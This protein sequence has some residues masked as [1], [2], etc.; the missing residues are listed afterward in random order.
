MPGPGRGNTPRTAN[1]AA[2]AEPENRAKAN[3]RADGTLKRKEPPLTGGASLV[4]K[5]Q[6]AKS[7]TSPDDLRTITAAPSRAPLRST[8]GVPSASSSGASG[9][10][11]QEAQAS[12]TAPHPSGGRSKVGA[13]ESEVSSVSRST[14]ACTTSDATALPTFQDADGARDE[15]E[16]WTIHLLGLGP[17]SHGALLKQL[18]GAYKQ[19][20][21]SKMPAEA[22]VNRVLGRVAEVAPNR[23]LR[24]RQGGLARISSRW[25]HYTASQ[26]ATLRLLQATAGIYEDD[27]DADAPVVASQSTAPLAPVPPKTS[28]AASGRVSSSATISSRGVDGGRVGDAGGGGG[29][30]HGGRGG[31]G[32]VA[33]APPAKRAVD[34]AGKARGSGGG[35]DGHSSRPAPLPM[36]ARLAPRA[37]A[38]AAPA[39]VAPAAATAPHSPTARLEV[40]SLT[41]YDACKRRFARGYSRY[42]ELDRELAQHTADFEDLLSGLGPGA[43]AGGAAAG[44][45]ARGGPQ[46]EEARA[47]AVAARMQAMW[48]ERREV[49]H[50]KV[51]EYRTLHVELRD[52]QAVTNTFVHA[53]ESARQSGTR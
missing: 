52:L 9:R 51:K 24:L 8:T 5:K 19:R 48:D 26:R 28:G 23:M 7:S 20:E 16:E 11:S 13:S 30:G 35:G 10:T 47:E 42:V 21:L 31:R 17:Q 32:G 41:Q 45:A 2:T 40:R 34:T 22:A 53:V 1:C 50:Q 25:S 18:A 4:V 29:G 27:E 44:G 39:T 12:K 33:N 46:A 6:K 14:P 15:L 37:R 38:A 49:L 43:A 3:A 36:T